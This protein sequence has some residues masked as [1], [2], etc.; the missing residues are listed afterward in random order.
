[1]APETLPIQNDHLETVFIIGAGAIYLAPQLIISG[2]KGKEQD[3]GGGNLKRTMGNQQ[4]R[5]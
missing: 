4:A 2:N 3:Y 1:M 5:I